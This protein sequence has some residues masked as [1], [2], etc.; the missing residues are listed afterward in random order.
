MRV[1]QELHL[2]PQVG[3]RRSWSLHPDTRSVSVLLEDRRRDS[4]RALSSARLVRL[5]VEDPSGLGFYRRSFVIAPGQLVELPAPGTAGLA[6]EVLG[7]DH[8]DGDVVISEHPRPRPRRVDSPPPLFDVVDYGVVDPANDY[9]PPPGAV[10]WWLP[11]GAT[12]PAVGSWHHLGG[13]EI[14]TG[15]VSGQVL[16]P[17][18]RFGTAGAAVVLWAVEA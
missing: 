18:F 4:D 5:R 8:L 10:R 1:L 9:T 2:S 7:G 11:Q 3:R 16:G 17:L 13:V 6:V 15:G 14:L 12:N